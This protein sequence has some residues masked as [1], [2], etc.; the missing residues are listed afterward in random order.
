[1]H[2]SDTLKSHVHTMPAT[3]LVTTSKGYVAGDNTPGSTSGTV[4]TNGTGAAE[5][6]PVHTYLNPV[7]YL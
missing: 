2:K 3:N 7:V 5:T 6:A 1:M 4:S